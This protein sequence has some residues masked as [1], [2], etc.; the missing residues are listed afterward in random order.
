M[1]RNITLLIVAA[2]F[3]GATGCENNRAMFPDN[4]YRLPTQHADTQAAKGALADGTLYLR[5]F[6]GDKLN[7]LGQDK[8]SLM[9]LGAG[10]STD[11]V[12]VYFDM[13]EPMATELRKEVVKQFLA[14]RG[15]GND[16]LQLAIGPNGNAKEF[17]TVTS[18]K[19]YKASDVKIE[20]SPDVN[21]YGQD[22]AK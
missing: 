6:S 18:G 9:A 13:P 3:V 14:E 2:S 20:P 4:T 10:S 7:S 16:R 21:L 1:N 11:N 15:I 12:A 5:H 8:L 17:S 19:L 22:E